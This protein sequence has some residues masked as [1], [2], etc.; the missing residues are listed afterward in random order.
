M[1]DADEMEKRMKKQFE[2]DKRTKMDDCPLCRLFW[3][4]DVKTKV[5]HKDRLCIIV[6]GQSSFCPLI[7]ARFHG[8]NPN[9]SEM[10]HMVNLANKLFPDRWFDFEN[11]AVPLHW[12]FHIR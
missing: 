6:E 2:E 10:N 8:R 7:V 4:G 5:Y 3:E 12:H 11:H 1:E 9:G